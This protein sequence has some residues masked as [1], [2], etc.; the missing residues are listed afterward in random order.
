MRLL[1][2]L[3]RLVAAKVAGKISQRRPVVLRSQLCRSQQNAAHREHPNNG[4]LCDSVCSA[5]HTGLAAAGTQ[6]CRRL[7]SFILG[8]E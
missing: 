3:L 8:E 7:D 1:H 2:L 5:S 4:E 6:L